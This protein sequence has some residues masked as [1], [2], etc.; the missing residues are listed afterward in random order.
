M[1]GFRGDIGVLTTLTNH[2]LLSVCNIAMPGLSLENARVD[3]F[4]DQILRLLT[5]CATHTTCQSA[6]AD[7]TSTKWSTASLS[8]S[9]RA[10]P[11]T[12]QSKP[13]CSP[14]PQRSRSGRRTPPPS[15]W[16]GGAGSR[17]A[18]SAW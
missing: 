14:L 17:A 11:A 9:P 18:R 16:G 2:L 12:T 1:D 8:V 15:P 13:P 5:D 7:Q 6:L 4:Q 3:S 10:S